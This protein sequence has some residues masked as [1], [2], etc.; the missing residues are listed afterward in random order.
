MCRVKSGVYMTINEHLTKTLPGFCSASSK[1][2]KNAHDVFVRK[3]RTTHQRQNRMEQILLVTSLYLALQ[4]IM[5]RIMFKPVPYGF[6]NSRRL[7]RRVSHR[8]VANKKIHFEIGSHE[9]P[10]HRRNKHNGS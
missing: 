7:A 1:L 4:A 9:L 10:E 3:A 8:D 6:V 2:P 5:L